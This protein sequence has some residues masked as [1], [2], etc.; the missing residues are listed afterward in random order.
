MIYTWL[1]CPKC[2]EEAYPKGP[3]SVDYCDNC[4]V[5]EGQCEVIKEER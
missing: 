3:D 5:V 4:G 1:Q 2:G